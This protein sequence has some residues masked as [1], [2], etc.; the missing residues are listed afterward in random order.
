MKGSSS[1]KKRNNQH[2]NN[3]N[4]YEQNSSSGFNSSGFNDAAAS[5]SSKSAAATVTL[6]AVGG[7]SGEMDCDAGQE[8]DPADG[9]Y[10]SYRLNLSE[11]ESR[12]ATEST[13][14][15]SSSASST[16]NTNITPSMS[17][18]DEDGEDNEDDSDINADDDGSGATTG[19]ANAQLFI[20]KIKTTNHCANNT[21][22]QSNQSFMAKFDQDYDGQV[23]KIADK[24]TSLIANGS[25]FDCGLYQFI[26]F[27]FVSIAWTIGNG[28][29]AYVSVFSGYTPDFECDY[30]NLG[31]NFTHHPDDKQCLALNSLTNQTVKC[32]K[33]IYDKSQLTSTIITEF[34][35]VCDKNY[36]FEL[37]YSIEQIGYIIGTLIFSFIADK[38]GRKPVFVGVIISM[39]LLGILQ[40]FV[41]DLFMYFVIGFVI[42]SLA[43]G[44]EAVCVTLVLEMFSTSKRTLFG[45]GIEVVWVIIL[46]SMSPLAYLIQ[47]WREIR[48]AIFFVLAIL[49]LLSFCMVQ[50]SIR[51]LISVEKLDEAAVIVNRIAKYNRLNKNKTPAASPNKTGKFKL[52]K[53]RLT[54]M[55][56]QLAIYNKSQQEQPP[57][58]IVVIKSDNEQDEPTTPALP[59]QPATNK[60]TTSQVV[61]IVKHPKFRMY[62]IIMAL[63]WFATALVYDGLTYLNNYIGENIFFNWIAMNMIELPAQFV[64]YI[65]LSRFGR[66]LTTSV[67]LVLVGFILLLTCL[68]SIEVIAQLAWFKLVL[69]VMAKFIITQSY[70]AVILHAP[71]LF[72]TNLRS[73]GYGISLFS[74]KVTAC[75]SPMIS[76]YL[77]KIYPTLPSLI[78]GIISVVCGFISLYV[79]ETLN[80]PLPNSIED[81]LK[82]PRTLTADEW[83]AVDE[84]NRKEFNMKKLKKCMRTNICCQ[85]E[86]KQPQSNSLKKRSVINTALNANLTGL[87]NKTITK[88]SSSLL[89]LANATDL[90][91]SNNNLVNKNKCNLPATASLSSSSAAA[92]LI[93]MNSIGNSATSE[94]LPTVLATSYNHQQQTKEKEKEVDIDTV[95]TFIASSANSFLSESKFELISKQQVKTSMP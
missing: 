41:L 95:E 39:S 17:S 76:I 80:R 87:E 53:Q 61:D 43:C 52:N 20:N 84:L 4:N 81:V 55:F 50:E 54:D 56:S 6:A 11:S 68:D 15:S 5:S 57:A 12:P 38:I 10:I 31:E 63:N 58:E 8:N 91:K 14:L 35:L 40:Y 74:G 69:F 77:G 27:L 79:P 33:W 88:S 59:S 66:R 65:V 60:R 62:V 45:I 23:E 1:K 92:N 2:F 64:C 36:Y 82:W 37:A 7:G 48:L 18:E 86:K 28:W 22:N 83:K 3:S 70:S 21:N 78:Y 94:L 51:W 46:A 34:D 29:Y 47:T 73:F 72:P 89:A 71:E 93:Q 13:M 25:F 90:N 24:A 85:K 44:L 30:K 32:N 67:T 49:S 42:N 75:I 16:T 19:Q 26:S 9:R